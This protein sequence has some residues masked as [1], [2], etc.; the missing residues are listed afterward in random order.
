MSISICSRFT[1]FL[2]T[3]LLSIL[4][5]F[6]RMFA[7]S[8][9][10]QAPSVTPY[11]LAPHL[12]N[13]ILD[14]GRNTSP[15][16]D[17]EKGVVGASYPRQAIENDA[18]SHGANKTVLCNS[19]AAA[20]VPPI[21][22]SRAVPRPGVQ[23]SST[24]K[25]KQEIPQSSPLSVVSNFA[26]VPGPP[27][28]PTLPKTQGENSDPSQGQAP[29]KQ[30][31]LRRIPRYLN[32]AGTSPTKPAIKQSPRGRSNSS[33]PYA[34]KFMDRAAPCQ[35]VSSCANGPSPFITPLKLESSLPGD[36][37]DW[38]ARI[39]SVFY[40]NREGDEDLSESVRN[41]FSRDST[42]SSIDLD[43][44]TDLIKD[45][46][47]L[48]VLDDEEDDYGRPLSVHSTCYSPSS[49]TSSS[50]DESFED[51][52]PVSP[53]TCSWSSELP[54]LRD[55][56]SA[57]SLSSSVSS[58]AFN[59]LLAS[60][61]RK[62]PGRYWK[63]IIQFTSGDEEEYKGVKPYSGIAVGQQQHWSDVFCI[64]EYAH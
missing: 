23:W 47:L 48:N 36:S 44:S 24:A 50:S 30:S 7:H 9:P 28:K 34:I 29:R 60:V 39:R 3:T 31:P 16:M 8:P 41:L 11:P 61:E 56:Q 57:L 19:E 35:L 58:G 62:Y 51:P 22:V 32:L 20:A 12:E 45:G 15:G 5:F 53:L 2:K 25:P 43:H 18:F 38:A 33:G 42:R 37:V 64:D 1:T 54:Y 4:T 40:K 10:H 17:L 52:P 46:D 63:G 59:D 55:R 13:C 26:R 21:P 27:A 6:L 14:I 49:P